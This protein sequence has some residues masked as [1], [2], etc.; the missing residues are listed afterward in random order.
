MDD[1]DCCP[2]ANM[3]VLAMS[4]RNTGQVVTPFANQILE[5]IISNPVDL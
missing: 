3:P 1:I 2:A 5:F 4:S